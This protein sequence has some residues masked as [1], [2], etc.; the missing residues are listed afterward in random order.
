MNSICLNTW[1]RRGVSTTP[2]NCE[3]FDSTLAAAATSLAG[4]AGVRR[5]WTLS[6]TCSSSE[7]VCTVSIVSTNS[8]Y[9]RGVGTR[10]AEVCGLETRPSSSR[11]DITLRIVAG[12]NSSPEYFESVREPTG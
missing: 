11:S 6:L 5:R 9:A 12:D 10:P 4:S 7:S 8:R 1:L 2:A 3:R